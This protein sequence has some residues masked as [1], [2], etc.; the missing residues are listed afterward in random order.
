[1]TAGAVVVFLKY[2]EPGRV[3]TRLAATVG[4]ERA[5]ELYREW[6]G[7]VLTALQPLRPDVAIV[8]AI[9]GA[10][11]AQFADWSPLVDQWWPQ[12]AGRACRAAA[13]SPAGQRKI[14]CRSWLGC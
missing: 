8:G 6:I 13:R 11:A 1:M 2:P 4:G 7:R 3:K 14:R 10:P 12:P 9:D 5:A